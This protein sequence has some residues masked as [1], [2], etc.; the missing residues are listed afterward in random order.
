MGTDRLQA[1]IESFGVRRLGASGEQ[2]LQDLYASYYAWLWGP[3]ADT[4]L[5]HPTRALVGTRVSELQEGELLPLVEAARGAPWGMYPDYTFRG[6]QKKA[7]FKR[8]ASPEQGGFGWTVGIG[9]DFS[10]IYAPVQE[11]SRTLLLA[12]ALGLVSAAVLTFFVARR[13][14]QPI[15]ELEAHTRRLAAGDLEQRLGWTRRD[16]LG[17][18][19]RGFDRMAGELAEGRRV[20][21]R[22][23]KDAAWREM[24]RQVAHEIK[25][26]LTP[27]SLSIGLLRRA[28]DEGSPEAES[29]LVRTMDMIE[30]QVAAMREIARDFHSFAGQHR[31]LEP[32]DLGALLD[33]VLELSAAWAAEESVQLVREGDGGLV[34]GDPGEL[35]RALL[36]LV[37]NAIEASDG[38]GELRARCEVRGNEVEVELVDSGR[39]LDPE[40]VQHLFEPYFTTRTSGTGL[41]LAIVRRVVEDLGGRVSL[42]NRSDGRGAVARIVLPRWEQGAAS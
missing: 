21:M 42:E 36:N 11:V 39:G 2:P 29:I 20:A 16:E 17:D 7:A 9:A 33:E 3:D 23:E 30:R 5:A 27:I 31:D 22:A 19:A 1:R 10:D 18:L 35:R 41:G 32:V 34:L 8:T 4:I 40:Q 14:A 6:I 13:T 28:R 25:N 15:Q 26:P 24:A 37:S 12:A 38:G